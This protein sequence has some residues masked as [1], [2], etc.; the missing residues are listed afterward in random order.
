MND[1]SELNRDCTFGKTIGGRMELNRIRE[2]VYTNPTQWESDRLNLGKSET[3]RPTTIREPV[4]N[5]PTE[6]WIV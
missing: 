5:C 6:G 4:L 3:V 2:Y 1:A